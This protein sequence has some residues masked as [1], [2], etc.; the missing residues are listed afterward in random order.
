M[1]RVSIIIPTFKRPEFLKTT[2]ENLQHQT[3]RDFEIIV[4]DDGTP[5]N[6]N[7][8]VCSNFPNVIYHKIPNSGGPMRPRNTGFQLS[9][10]EYLALVDDDDLWAHDKL[11][12]QVGVLDN[13]KEFGLAHSCCKV[14]D[15]TGRET[16]EITG[17]LS[18]PGLKH[19]YV[20]DQMVGNFTVMTPTAI[21]RKELLE[22]SGA[23]NE[24]MKAAGE[25]TEFF[26]RMAFYTRFYYF[27]EPLAWYRVHPGGI[28]T[29]NSAY[30]NL[31][32]E[33]SKM[34][35]TLKREGLDKKRHRKIRERLLLKQVAEIR[36]Y[37]SLKISLKNSFVMHP[38]FWIVPR[39][40]Y[41][42]ILKIA[43][44]ARNLAR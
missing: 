10:G 24:K 37:K 13:F 4:V 22:T 44:V 39:V 9:K 15:H 28:S 35:D 23:F 14:I 2:L 33:L 41:G 16:G 12:L 8:V 29:N 6:E 7:E 21:F 25:D 18:N 32:V 17:R 34:I 38:F 20:F 3:Y 5:G 27:D 43:K 26:S 36:D 31:P 30:I 42:T 19:G 1:P 40:A 11:E